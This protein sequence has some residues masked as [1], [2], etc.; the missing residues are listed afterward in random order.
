M[1]ST[2]AVSDAELANEILLI[3]TIFLSAVV[4]SGLLLIVFGD[5]LPGT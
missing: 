1:S 3:I 5:A 2:R 4:I